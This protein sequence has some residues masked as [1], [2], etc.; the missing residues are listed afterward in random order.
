MCGYC[1]VDEIMVVRPTPHSLSLLCSMR[2]ACV[3]KFHI[4][5]ENPTR[6]SVEDLLGR[7]RGSPAFTSSSQPSQALGYQAYARWQ[8]VT[9]D[10]PHLWNN[11][12]IMTNC[13]LGDPFPARMQEVF[14]HADMG[15][16]LTIDRRHYDGMPHPRY[17]HSL[18]QYLNLTFHTK[19][20]IPILC[21]PPGSINSLESV[22]MNL[23]WDVYNP[24][25]G[26]EILYY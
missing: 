20:F 14:T 15:I 12:S 24:F 5:P 17:H 11:I 19:Y 2:L 25:I 8:Q 26:L 18:F 7:M 13:K 22:R 3:A 10:E 6:G 1:F 16:T 23:E 21:C 4:A 9:L